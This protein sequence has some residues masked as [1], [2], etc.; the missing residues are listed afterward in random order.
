MHGHLV[1][2]PEAFGDGQATFR[3]SDNRTQQLQ[4]ATVRAEEF[5]GG[6]MQ[7]ILPPGFPKMR[8]CGMTGASQHVAPDQ[9]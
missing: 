8:Y 3:Y 6:F 5:I 4:R 1:G 9:A 2:R 7:Q